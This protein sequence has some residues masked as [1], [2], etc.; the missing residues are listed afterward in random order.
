MTEHDFLSL[1]VRDFIEVL[2]SAQPVPGG[3]GACALVG[4]LAAALGGMVGSLTLGKKKYADV[5]ED[6][7][8]LGEKTRALIGELEGLVRQDADVFEPLSRAYGM[9]QDTPEQ[10]AEKERVMEEALKEAARVPLTIM[11]KCGEAVPLLKEY[12][13]KGSRIAVSD[14]GTAAA[15]CRAALLGARLNVSVN[16]RL[17]KDRAAAEALDAK[18]E[19]LARIG[20]AGADAVYEDVLG[21][22]SV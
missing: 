13:E 21:R 12:A 9:S 19:E 22:L 8:L 3:G 4:A 5:Q 2:S 17:M 15:F 14:A 7:L 6:I 16:T 20:T 10:K 11:E 18:A 1:P